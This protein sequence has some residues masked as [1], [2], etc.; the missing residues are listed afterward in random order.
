MAANT[1]ALA[2]L[3]GGETRSKTGIEI[4]AGTATGTATID[5]LRSSEAT[6]GGWTP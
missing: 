5:A 6:D 3:V 2:I 4:R 1:S